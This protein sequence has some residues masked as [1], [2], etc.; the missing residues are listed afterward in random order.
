MTTSMSR[1]GG[2]AHARLAPPRRRLTQGGPI[3]SLVRTLSFFSKW[4]AEV[5]R[6]PA[7]MVSLVLGPFLILLLFGLGTKVGGAPKPRTI[8]VDALQAGQG[9]VRLQP[10][11]VSDYLT[12]VGT[13][14][15]VDQALTALRG[16]Q[17]ELVVVLPS[18]PAR[19]VSSGQRAKLQIYTNEIDPLRNSYA[20]AYLAYQI[21][22]LNQK[23]VRDAI[24]AAQRSAEQLPAMTAQARDYLARFRAA[25]A[26]AARARQELQAAR[27]AIT[28]LADMADQITA[29]LR[30]GVVFFPGLG[31]A[32]ARAERLSASIQQLGELAARLDARLAT[33]S[34]V[35]AGQLAEFERRLDEVDAEAG[36]LRLIPPEVLAAPF[37]L[38]YQTVAPHELSTIGFYA[39]AVLA[40]LLQ[41]LAVTLGALSM[42]RVRLLGLME[43]LQTSPVR[44]SEVVVGNYLAFGSFCAV[45]G[46]VLTLLLAFFLRVPIV[47]P[48]WAFISLVTL[49]IIASLG[50]GF[51]ISI[52]SHSEQQAAQ[53]AMLIL[54]ASVFFSGF[55]IYLEAIEWP[56]RAVAYLLPTTYAIRGLRDVM[57]RG[58]LLTPV[59]L[60]A[61]GAMSIGFFVLTVGLFRREFRSR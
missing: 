41:H 22:E 10:G 28:P 42:A 3:G 21:G 45:A 13:S 54:I 24:A 59:D 46:G 53:I 44:P 48:P 17:A 11:D 31:E 38:Q 2:Q 60:I 18:D 8:V 56:V 51:I 55:M 1:D 12:I 26:D 35:D 32:L 37:E 19:A 14:T 50:L 33:A 43:L 61:L 7:L 57:L 36:Q 39:P 9:Q 27:A 16:G 40:L 30:A 58:F 29:T 6:Q 25:Q 4:L 49:L 34:A 23:T 15:D 52:V 47:G 5:L 20:Q